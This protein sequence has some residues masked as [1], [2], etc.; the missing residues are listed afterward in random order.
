MRVEE[1]LPSC[2][3]YNPL[4]WQVLILEEPEKKLLQLP[5]PGGILLPHPLFTLMGL[6]LVQ[7]DPHL[8]LLELL[9]L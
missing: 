8:S 5:Q 2:D 3:H 9:R 6:A 7:A 4:D 1:L